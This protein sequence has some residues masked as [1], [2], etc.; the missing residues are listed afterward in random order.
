MLLFAMNLTIKL[1][2]AGFSFENFGG[3]DKFTPLPLGKVGERR[4][5]L[6]QFLVWGVSTILPIWWVET[7]EM[8]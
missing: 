2:K 5:Y 7:L 1:S 4:E 6:R 8:T 3:G